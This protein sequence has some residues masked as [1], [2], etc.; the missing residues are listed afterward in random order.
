[1]RQAATGQVNEVG[2]DKIDETLHGGSQQVF[3]CTRRFR[4]FV[5]YESELELA[6]ILLADF[7]SSA[8]GFVAQ[9]FL[10]DER[11]GSVL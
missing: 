6:R 8:C 4:H 11:T 9:P 10:V 5:A 2:A 7:D 3:R 1:L